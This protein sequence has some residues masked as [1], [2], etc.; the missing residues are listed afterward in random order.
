MTTDPNDVKVELQFTQAEGLQKTYAHYLLFK[1]DSPTL[2]AILNIVVPDK[3]ELFKNIFTELNKKHVNAGLAQFAPNIPFRWNESEYGIT[4]K[5]YDEMKTY[6]S[7]ILSK[8]SLS[9]DKMAKE[10]YENKPQIDFIHEMVIQYFP[11]DTVEIVKKARKNLQISLKEGYIGTKKAYIEETEQPKDI[12]ALELKV[13]NDKTDIFDKLPNVLH[14]EALAE[15]HRHAFLSADKKDVLEVIANAHTNGAK[16]V[17]EYI[18]NAKSLY[19]KKDANGEY[20]VSSI[21]MNT[22]YEK[23]IKIGDCWKKEVKQTIAK[24]QGGTKQKSKKARSK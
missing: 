23:Y 21:Q 1:E 10:M 9:P 17:S 24:T 15:L 18:P 11:E 14:L 7:P 22:A 5:Q 16:D 6:G 4:K 8:F 3:V 13:K 20:M 19:V 2:G 12:N